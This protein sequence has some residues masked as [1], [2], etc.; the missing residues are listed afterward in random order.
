MTL[1]RA[2]VRIRH[3]LVSLLLESAIAVTVLT[4]LIVAAPL[5]VILAAQLHGLATTGQWRGFQVSELLDVLRVDPETLATRPDSVAG[6]VLLLPA[7]LV[8][9]TATLAFCVLAAILHRANRRVCARLYS[10]Q[11]S[12]LIEDIERQL[13]HR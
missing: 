13:G 1:R 3:G 6:F 4:A 7:S 11:Q 5:I 12:A 8:L 2:L 9:F 10:M